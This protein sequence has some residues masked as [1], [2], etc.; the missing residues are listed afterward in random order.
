MSFEIKL[1][2]NLI[3]EVPEI[4]GEIKPQFEK[5]VFLVIVDVR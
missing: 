4:T 5:P 1:G 2:E 3:D